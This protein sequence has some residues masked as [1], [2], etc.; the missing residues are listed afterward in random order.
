MK[1]SDL[2]EKISLSTRMR[3]ADVERVISTVFN[4]ISDALANGNR[5]ELRGF[6]IF[7][8]R[9]RKPRN[10]RN[11]KTGAA[12]KV[13]AKSVPFFKAGKYLKQRINKKG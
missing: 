6:G 8:T 10:A 11:P 12:V 13:D 7:S 9:D 4:E 1:K 2:I 5:V 3:H